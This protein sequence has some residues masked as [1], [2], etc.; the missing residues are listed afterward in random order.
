[1]EQNHQI[2]EAR[3]VVDECL[4]LA[5]TDDQARYFA[6]LLD[7]REGRMES[8]ETRLRDLLRSG[9]RHPYV[10]YA[11]RYELAQ[12]LDRTERHDEAIRHLVEAKNLVKAL[13]DTSLLLRSYDR[14]AD[15]FRKFTTALPRDVLRRWASE[16]PLGARAEHPQI[17]FLG[18]H[19]RSGT[20]LLEQILDAHPEIAAL[21]EPTALQE[22]LLPRFY[23]ARDFS[24]GY[25]NQC[26]RE[27]VA[28]LDRELGPRTEGRLRLDKNPSPTSQLPLWLRFFPELKIVIALRDPRDVVLSCFFQNLVLNVTNVNFLSW[29]RLA[30][31]YADLMDVWTTVREWEGL[32]W[33]ESR[34]E[35]TVRQTDVEGR[36]VTEF[37]G[38][39]WSG[40][41]L[42][43]FESSRQKQFYSPT[44]QDVTRPVYSRS[45][46]RWHFYERHLAPILPLLE[47][48]CRRWGYS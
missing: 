19:P 25:L 36:R 28:A 39:H 4:R 32:E 46:A 44:Y 42:R 29:E 18:G 20:T 45:V 47:P 37:L 8:A 15:H 14:D 41:Q 16:F 9:P 23:G 26:R 34:Y 13:T 30:R 7:R 48:Y 24:H 33:I 21:D 27:Y 10:R 3:S 31:H 35:D 38:L 12:V 1:M 2:T 17:A 11:A 6:A 22:V 40:Q 43:F 5:P